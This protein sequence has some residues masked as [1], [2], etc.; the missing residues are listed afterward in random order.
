MRDFSGSQKLVAHEMS[1]GAASVICG[2]AWF[3]LT[4]DD[5]YCRT[6]FDRQLG[7]F[8]NH[9]LL[10]TAMAGPL[11]SAWFDGAQ[12]DV[13]AAKLLTTASQHPTA[14]VDGAAPDGEFA[15]ATLMGAALLGL[16]RD[17]P[18]IR[19]AIATAQLAVYLVGQLALDR[20]YVFASLAKRLDAE[21][22]IAIKVMASSFRAMISTRDDEPLPKGLFQTAMAA[23]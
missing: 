9:D 3:V 7:D 13:S 8:S 4:A 20:P 14:T 11:A 17:I 23:G 15:D 6:N 12:L 19:S 22:G 16:K 2:S 18:S 21:P 5:A 1:H 10:A